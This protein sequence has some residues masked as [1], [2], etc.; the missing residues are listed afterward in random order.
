MSRLKD[1]VAIVTGAASGMGL[2]TTRLF[3]EEGARV[4]GADMQEDLLQKELHAM[5]ADG[6]L[7]LGLVADISSPEG[8]Q[9]VVQKALDAFGRVDVL[10]NNAGIFSPEGILE[11]DPGTWE[12]ILAVD[13]AGVFWGMQAVIPTMQANGG[14]SIVNI[15][16]IAAMASGVGDNGGAA[17]S[18]AKGAVRSISRHAAR[19]FAKD[20]IRV[21]SIYPGPV[22]TPMVEQSGASREQVA[23]G[24]Q[25][26]VILPPHIGDAVD[27]AYGVL[28]LASDES[29]Y[30]TGTELVIDGGFLTQ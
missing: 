22:Y 9:K 15:A 2:A 20:S 28:Y 14:G 19:N 7:T 23:A 5:D 4:V 26:T 8:W 24:L 17:Y 29:R 18:A 27:I 25:E 30:V 1:K 21:N 10:V 16:S 3:V 12:K 13:A 6:E 11:T